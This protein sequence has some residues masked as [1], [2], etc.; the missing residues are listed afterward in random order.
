MT[1]EIWGKVIGKMNSKMQRQQKNIFL[2]CD[3]ASCHK[4]QSD[5]S[6]IKNVFMPPNTTPLIQP[7]DQGIT[8]TVKVYYKIQFI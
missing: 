1:S 2:F 4:L 3:N 5:M 8:R 6:N 7:L